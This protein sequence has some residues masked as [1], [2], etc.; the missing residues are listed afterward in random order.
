M[1]SRAGKLFFQW[2]LIA[3]TVGTLGC[4][5]QA[6]RDA[7]SLESASAAYA[8]GDYST[9][10][11]KFKPVAERG[12][13]VAQFTLGLMYREGQGVAKDVK[14]A[15]EWLRK[16]AEQGH[17]QAQENLGLSY[18]KG[19]GIERDWVQADMWF[20]IA[21]ASGKE[22]A[23]NNKKVVEVHMPPEKVAEANTLAQE[24]LAKHKK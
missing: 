22:T 8:K 10:L 14:A 9:A 23:V 13:P 17:A 5:D 15:V 18:A 11:K 2:M 7:S 19:Q 21:A 24:W 16:A 3:V 12:N 20:S 6:Q 4:S 1:I